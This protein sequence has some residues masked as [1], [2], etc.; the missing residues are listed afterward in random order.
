MSV[1]ELFVKGIIW[2]GWVGF[3]LLAAL[4]PF[5]IGW[6]VWDRFKHNDRDE[7]VRLGLLPEKKVEAEA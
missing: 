4:V 3:G 1:L 7:L 2:S 6:F 5:F